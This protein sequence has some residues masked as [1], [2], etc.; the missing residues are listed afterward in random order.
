MSDFTIIA[1]TS[2]TWN[3]WVSC[4]KV[5]PGC[6]N[7]Y[8]FTGQYRIGKDPT[9]VRKTKTWNDPHRWQRALAN[10]DKHELVFTCSWSDW[11][12]KDADEWRDDAWKVV[13]ETPNLW[14]QILTKRA[15]RMADHLPADWGQGYANVWLGVSAENQKYA[16]IRIPL[17]MKIPAAVHFVSYEPAL[18][19]IDF[20]QH[21]SSIDKYDKLSTWLI[22]GGESGPG[23]RKAEVAWAQSAR[24]QCKAAG[25]PFFHKQS[26]GPRTEMGIELDGKIVREYPTPRKVESEF[27]LT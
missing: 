10:T 9:K 4:T 23:F 1:W 25:I 27:K 2:K 15:E 20:G 6:T 7:C 8:M 24:D 22:Y 3:P 11:F 18:G 19:P 14:Y 17:L 16:D 13:R 12:H 5:S 26:S 21:F